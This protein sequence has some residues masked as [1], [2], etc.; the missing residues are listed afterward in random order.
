MK[1]HKYRVRKRNIVGRS[2]TSINRVILV[3]YFFDRSRIHLAYID[4]VQIMSHRATI[5]YTSVMDKI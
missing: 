4:S 5:N 2:T 1:D 3:S